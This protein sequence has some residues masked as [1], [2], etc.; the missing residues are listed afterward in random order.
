MDYWI[1]KT[2]LSGLLYD[3]PFVGRIILACS[4]PFLIAYIV[5]N[6]VSIWKKFVAEGRIKRLVFV[7]VLDA[8]L[9]MALLRFWFASVGWCEF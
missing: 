8:F 2:T 4:I 1:C 9:I 6:L 3:S 7:V 5:Y